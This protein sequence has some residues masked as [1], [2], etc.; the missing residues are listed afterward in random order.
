MPS[1]GVSKSQKSSEFTFRRFYE[2]DQPSS[3]SSTY[4]FNNQTRKNYTNF[5]NGRKLNGGG[6]DD[7]D[8]Q[9]VSIS[10]KNNS[11]TR[12]FS[13]DMP[14]LIPISKTFQSSITTNGYSRESS[15]KPVAS[16]QP[17]RGRR[18][19]L[20]FLGKN[21]VSPEGCLAIYLINTDHPLL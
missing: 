19:V 11:A 10:P 3:S 21:R 16:Q 9:L 7:D 2:T 4:A 5:T 15:V 13:R 20:D 18:S 12:P 6:Q 8:I 14:S 17:I 1:T